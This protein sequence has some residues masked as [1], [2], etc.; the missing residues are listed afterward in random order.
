MIPRYSRPEMADIWSPETRFRIWFEIEAHACDA[1]AELGV[2]PKE[3]ART[4]WEKGGP[5]KGGEV[6]TV[7]EERLARMSGQVAGRPAR[8]DLRRDPRAVDLYS[9]LFL[10]ASQPY[11]RT[12]LGWITNG[13]LLDPHAEFLI[14]ESPSVSRAEVADDNLNEYWEKRYVI[15]GDS[16]LSTRDQARQNGRGGGA[17]VPR[18]LQSWRKKILLT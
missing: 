2:I 6:L 10:R 9:S 17:I 8:T 12:L 1:L 13:H 7:I 11:A 14:R 4:I 5:V 3:A 16:Q 18:C 15:L